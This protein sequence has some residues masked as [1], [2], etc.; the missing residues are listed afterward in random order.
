MFVFSKQSEKKKG[1]KE[2]L[3]STPKTRAKEIPL[4]GLKTAL[5]SDC[6]AECLVIPAQVT[7]GIFVDCFHTNTQPA[8]AGL[9]IVL[10][11]D[12]KH[13]GCFSLATIQNPK[14]K[15]KKETKPN[16]NNQT[17]RETTLWINKSIM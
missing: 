12:S 6:S 7:A 8:K 15:K 1:L 9:C 3:S 4:K 17:K 2:E 11:K 16:D 5:R 10:P 14:K 13:S